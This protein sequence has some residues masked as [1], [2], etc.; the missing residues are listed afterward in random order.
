MTKKVE[1]L[2][3]AARAELAKIDAMGGSVVAVESGYMKEQL[4]DSNRRRAEGI[5]RGD[6]TVVGVNKFTN[7]EPSPLSA[8]EG[9]IQTVDFTA[10]DNQ[11]HALKAWR[12]KRDGKAVEAALADLRVT[13]QENRNIME[14]SIAA[15]KA[16]AT[17]GEWGD[18]LRE[19]YG[20]FRAPTGVALV[21]ESEGEDVAAVKAEVARLS[22]KPRPRAHVRRRQTRARWAFQ[23]RR[24][25]R[26]ARARCRHERGL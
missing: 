3:E 8:G 14:V 6:L 9:I 5:E 1:A 24:A 25:D 21:I 18:T 23:R 2:K 11:L 19:V 16:G 10:E 13:A 15:A 26:G 12:A 7:A 20:E 17:T 4:V 22:E